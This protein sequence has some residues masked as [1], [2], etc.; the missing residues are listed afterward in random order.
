MAEAAD[1]MY[2]NIANLP[3]GLYLMQL[4][5]ATTPRQTVKVYKY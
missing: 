4:H 1:A 2:I 5:N 3:Q